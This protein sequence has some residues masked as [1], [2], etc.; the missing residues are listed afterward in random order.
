M[1]DIEL[2]FAIEGRDRPLTCTSAIN[3]LVYLAHLNA[4]T[5]GFWEGEYNYPEKLALIHQEVSELLEA[6][7]ASSLTEKCDKPIN[8]TNEEEEMADILIRI[9]DLAG[10]RQ[11]DLGKAVIFKMLYN[12]TRPHKHGKTC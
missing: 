12:T 5:K 8:L 11:V 1:S 3:R 2:Q 10:K 4:V 7:R 6:Y 9:F